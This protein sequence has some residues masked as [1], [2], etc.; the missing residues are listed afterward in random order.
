MRRYTPYMLLAPALLFTVFILLYPMAQNLVNSFRDVSLIREGG[1]WNG[2][3]NYEHVFGDAVFWLAFRNTAVYAV[4]GTL[5]AL[6][7]GLSLHW[8]STC[9]RGR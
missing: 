6:L 2:F 3:L 5:L 9:T 7:I 8:C 4:A 1:G